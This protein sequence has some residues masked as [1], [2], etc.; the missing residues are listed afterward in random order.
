SDRR[1]EP[2]IYRA[3]GRRP[4]TDRDL[5][6]PAEAWLSPLERRLP[7][8]FV[9]SDVAEPR[10]ARG[11]QRAFPEL[12]AEVPRVR[13][14]DD[15]AG[16]IVRG[17]APPDQFVETE[18]LRTG[19]FNGAVHRRAHGDPADP[20][21]DVISRHGLKEDRRHADRRSD[22]GVIGNAFDELE[23]LRGVNDR[24]RD[25]ATP[26]QSLLSALRAEVRAVR[27]PLRADHGQRD[28][29]L[30]ARRGGVLEKV[31]RRCR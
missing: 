14:G 28:V 3:A 2:W 8:P 6:T 29:M 13:I 12:G 7:E 22:R 20:R 21:R 31:T 25:P 30:H 23:E 24:V 1:V 16:V 9:E 18:L 4:R 19:H 15:L 27:D 26:D 17:E 5:A 10:L 11:N